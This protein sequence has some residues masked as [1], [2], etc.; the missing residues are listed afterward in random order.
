VSERI[1]GHEERTFELG[2]TVFFNGPG[3]DRLRGEVVRVYNTRAHYHVE[4]NGI[5]YSV[6]SL[7]D[8]MVK[9]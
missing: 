6:N 4:V 7:D 9:E 1:Y 3:G 5:R 8:D 2:D